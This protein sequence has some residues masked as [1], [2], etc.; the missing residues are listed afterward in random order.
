MISPKLYIS[1]SPRWP[2][3]RTM[4]SKLQAN[5]DQ[6]VL[7]SDQKCGHKSMTQ[8]R[9]DLL[10]NTD[11]F[12]CSHFQTHMLGWGHYTVLVSYSFALSLC[13]SHT[14]PHMASHSISLSL[15]H[16]L[17]LGISYYSGNASD[18]QPHI[19]THTFSHTHTHKDESH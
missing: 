4:T 3:C 19:Y 13:L 11:T 6:L 17:T 8:T 12:R 16:S 14:L 15:S 7:I 10:A 5:V 18:G 9:T 1:C 2:H